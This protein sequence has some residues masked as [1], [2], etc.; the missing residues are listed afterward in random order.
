MLQKTTNGVVTKY[1]YGRGLIGEE[2][3]SAFKTYHFDSRGSTVAIT[4]MVGNITDTFAY[5][6]YGKLISRTGTSKVIFG[7]NGRDGVVT[8]TNG[9]IYMR[10]RYYSP[11]M[12][13]FVNAD[14]IPG[15]ISNAITL[16]RFAYANGNPVSFVDP[17]GLSFLL[18]LGLIALGAVIG[19][20][21][22]AVSSAVEQKKENGEVNW[23]EVA[24]DA[25]WGA[26]DGGISASPLGFVGKTIA[27]GVISAGQS[28]TDQYFDSD[29][30]EDFDLSD[31]DYLEVGTSVAID[32]GFSMLDIKKPNKT[33]E[34]NKVVSE[35]D[36][37]IA[38][39]TRRANKEVAQKRIAEASLKKSNA[40]R[41]TVTDMLIDPFV[42]PFTPKQIAQ[43]S[44]E[45]V[46]DKLFFDNGEETYSRK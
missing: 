32:V 5:D 36:N 38:R 37:K 21:V 20:T 4:D 16:N 13:R 30:K 43:N 46:V 34:L 17:I 39:E 8:D 42:D 14:I 19:G 22:S 35:L 11:A 31:V 23:K 1:V 10:A 33:K 24:V 25:A 9:L 2:V 26:L 45:F 29:N 18:T 7:Y 40:I 44:V 15:E 28:I 6:T 27:S 3:G 41:G 12:K